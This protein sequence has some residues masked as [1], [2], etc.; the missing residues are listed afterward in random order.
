MQTTSA[1]PRDKGQLEISDI[2]DEKRARKGTAPKV[3]RQ[4]QISS[5]ALL[6]DAAAYGPIKPPFRFY[7]WKMHLFS[8]GGG[9]GGGWLYSP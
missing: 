1:L 5:L 4:R 2:W 6:P 8:T 7:R 3:Q 9:G